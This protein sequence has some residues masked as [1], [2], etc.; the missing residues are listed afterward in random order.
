MNEKDSSI[1]V[2]ADE[3]TQEYYESCCDGYDEFKST[4]G[5]ILPFR[6][7]IP[8]DLANIKKGMR[9]VDIGS[10]RGELVLHC[11]ER[12]ALV[13]GLD[14]ASEAL[15]LVNTAL[16]DIRVAFSDRLGFQQ[17][18]ARSLPFA[19]GSVD[20]VFMLDIVEHLYP[21]ELK[22]TFDEVWR[23]LIPDGRVIVHTMPNLWYYRYGYPLFRTIQSIRGEKLPKNPRDRWAFS[24]VHE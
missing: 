22:K 13:W 5:R 14:Y 17:A 19:S 12:G 3:Y 7:Q 1:T 11:A 8:L 20:V 10:G 2:P 9:V 15:S 6:L 23:I 16:D 18:D 4:Q 24:H 21:D